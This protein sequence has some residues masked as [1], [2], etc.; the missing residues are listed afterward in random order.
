L[1]C[2]DSASVSGIWKKAKV[3][4]PR[5]KLNTY[6][7]CEAFNSIVIEL[8]NNSQETHK[9]II[10]PEGEQTEKTY[11]LLIN[12]K[13]TIILSSREDDIKTIPS[14]ET[15]LIHLNVSSISYIN[16]KDYLNKINTVFNKNSKLLYFYTENKSL[17]DKTIIDKLEI[18]KHENFK[19]EVFDN[20]E[21]PK[22]IINLN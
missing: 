18:Y 9:L 4:F 16:K 19:V 17:S 12:N 20:F 5:R 7:V 2:T 6:D 22:S 11:F 13:D 15:V 10:H 14:N 1:T 8:I 3:Y 21:Y